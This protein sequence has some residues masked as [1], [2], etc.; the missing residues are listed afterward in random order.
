MKLTYRTIRVL[1]YMSIAL[2]TMNTAL[3]YYHGLSDTSH[4]YDP[5]VGLGNEAIVLIG[6]IALVISQCLKIIEGRLSKLESSTR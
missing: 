2:G 3:D 5:G 4:T 1:G 6:V